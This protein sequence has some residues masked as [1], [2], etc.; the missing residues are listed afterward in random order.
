MSTN[1]LRIIS[2]IEVQ[3]DG[4]IVE[5]VCLNLSGA[6]RDK[7]ENQVIKNYVIPTLKE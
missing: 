5:Y 4:Q 6:Y 3:H 7:N 1:P 2:N